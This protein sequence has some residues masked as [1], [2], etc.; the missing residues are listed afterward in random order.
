MIKIEQLGDRDGGSH[1]AHSF[2]PFQTMSSFNLIKSVEDNNL[3]M[4]TSLT[5]AVLSDCAASL[6]TNSDFQKESY[7]DD[8]FCKSNLNN[9]IEK[10]KAEGGK[11]ARHAVAARYAAI[12]LRNNATEPDCCPH[13]H[14][15]IARTMEK[16][17]HDKYTD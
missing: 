10:V 14:I 7:A 8:C 11:R 15:W 6:E 5:N 9:I 16:H 1:F 2:L 3:Q 12:I 4:D 13:R 17:I